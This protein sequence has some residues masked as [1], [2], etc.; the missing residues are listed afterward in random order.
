MD[1]EQLEEFMEDLY[2]K[3]SSEDTAKQMLRKHF[4]AHGIE[5]DEGL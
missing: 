3:E 2:A 1:E 5:W 4:E